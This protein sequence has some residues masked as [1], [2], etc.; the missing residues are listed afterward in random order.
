MKLHGS[1]LQGGQEL[2]ELEHRRI[3]RDQALA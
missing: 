2:Q 3:F 1:G